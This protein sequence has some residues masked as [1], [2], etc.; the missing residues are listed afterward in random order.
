MT[1]EPDS[2]LFWVSE[3]GITITACSYGQSMLRA[4]GNKQLWWSSIISPCAPSTG[5]WIIIVMAY[6]ELFT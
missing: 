1:S 6:L 3:H 4:A 2:L 5:D